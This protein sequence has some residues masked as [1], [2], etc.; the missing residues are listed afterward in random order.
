ML[1]WQSRVKINEDGSTYKEKKGVTLSLDLLIENISIR[2][3]AAYVT[4]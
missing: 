1:C 3:V 2:S 4:F